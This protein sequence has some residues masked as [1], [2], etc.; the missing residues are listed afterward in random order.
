M[1]ET[2]HQHR[3]QQNREDL[4]GAGQQLFLERGFPGVAVKD[5]CELAGVSR[6]TY[7]KH[8]ESIEE[9]VFEVQMRALEH[10]T[11][12]V[13]A[14]DDSHGDGASRLLRTLEVWSAYAADH[15]AHMRFILL[16]DLHYDAYPPERKLQERYQAFIQAKKEQHFLNGPLEAG[17][18]DGSLRSDLHLYDT[19]EFIFTAMMG[20]LQKLSLTSESDEREAP[21]PAASAEAKHR[22]ISRRFMDMI[23][24]SLRG[25]G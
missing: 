19:G 17:I 21:A 4:I 1:T 24:G 18:H 8:F 10:M 6:V 13:Q 11:D 14:A 3:K 15:K 9:L 25:G 16:F 7:Y 12:F 20:L 23:L 5:V 22:S 2:W